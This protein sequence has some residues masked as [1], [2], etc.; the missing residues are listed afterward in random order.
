MEEIWLKPYVSQDFDPKAAAEAR[1]AEMAGMNE[2]I[3][4][5]L[6]EITAYLLL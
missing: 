1:K 2:Q 6:K 3:N 4:Q 5:R